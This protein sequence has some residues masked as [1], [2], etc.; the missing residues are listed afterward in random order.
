MIFTVLLIR[1]SLYTMSILDKVWNSKIVCSFTYKQNKQPDNSV[2]ILIHRN[3][4]ILSV[5]PEVFNYFQ[6]PESKI[7]Y[8]T[9]SIDGKEIDWSIPTDILHNIYAYGNH[10]DLTIEISKLPSTSL[11]SSSSSFS[12]LNSLLEKF[13]HNKLKESCYILNNSSNIVMSMSIKQSTE[14]W[15]SVINYDYKTFETYFKKLTNSLLNIP[16]KVYIVNELK[17]YEMK[18]LNLSGLNFNNSKLSIIF[19]KLSIPENFNIYCHGIQLPIDSPIWEVYLLL[20]HFDTF[21][22]LVIKP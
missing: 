17:L 13:W 7:P 3:S 2:F 21:I 15:N 14:F 18:Q 16:C 6:I 1:S 19:D 4:Y 20:K 12:E 11:I 8:L 10:L 5:L 9:L 22:H